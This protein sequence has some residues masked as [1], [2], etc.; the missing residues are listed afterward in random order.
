MNDDEIRL[1][2]SDR[3]ISHLR[4]KIS[5]QTDRLSTLERSISALK[6]NNDK[7]R[8]DIAYCN[9]QIKKLRGHHEYHH[10]IDDEHPS[11]KYDTVQTAP[12]E[13]E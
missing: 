3:L 1:A 11:T 5:N 6:R 12:K 2:N 9:R 8:K 7:L 13:I 10:E 4:N